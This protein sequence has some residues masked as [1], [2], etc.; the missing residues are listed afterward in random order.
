MCIHIKSGYFE[1]H[2]YGEYSQGHSRII[3]ELFSIPTRMG[4]IKDSFR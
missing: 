3:D 2:A 4:S 1:P